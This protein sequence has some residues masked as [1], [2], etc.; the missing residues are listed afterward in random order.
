[1][2]DI[3]FAIHFA[4]LFAILLNVIFRL[5][6]CIFKP[7]NGTSETHTCPMSFYSTDL[8]EFLEW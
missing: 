4:I 2:F 7:E 3:L 5:L 8:F 6:F 1:M